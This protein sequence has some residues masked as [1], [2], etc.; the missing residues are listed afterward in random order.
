MTPPIQNPQIYKK[1]KYHHNNLQE[2]A[3]LRAL[4]VVDAL[5]PDGLTL[6]GLARD[7]GVTAAALVYYFG[8][9]AGLRHAVA[10]RVHEQM[11]PFILINT[12]GSRAAAAMELAARR[13][14]DFAVA[15]PHRYRMA[16]GEGFRG[17]TCFRSVRRM[18]N[19]STRRVVSVAQKAGLMLAANP[20]TCGSVSF[21]ALHGL[22]HARADGDVPAE[23][24]GSIIRL[25]L[26]EFS[27]AD[28]KRPTA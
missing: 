11:R 5:G 17:N 24:T 4:E 6:R 9:R 12:G 8:N 14:V 23:L 20:D 3:I 28:P 19:H 21:A 1:T 10:Q 27:R 25:W 13:W 26:D 18:W 22:A 7:L 16:F 15:Y 2:T